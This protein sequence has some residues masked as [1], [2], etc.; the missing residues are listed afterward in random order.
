MNDKTV[1]VPT[2]NITEAAIVSS[3]AV[4]ESVD[5][6]VLYAQEITNG[7]QLVDS[8]PKVVYI[9]MA[10]TMKDVF[11]IKNSNG[12]IYKK[13]GSWVAEY[14]EGEKLVRKILNIKLMD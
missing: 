13:E 10:T 9:A 4:M 12:V 8:S 11:I 1:E 14:Y 7:Y 3:P 5:S 6:N 2:N